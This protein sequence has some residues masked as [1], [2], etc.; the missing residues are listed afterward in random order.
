MYFVEL[1]QVI[2]EEACRLGIKGPWNTKSYLEMILEAKG[3][4]MR[5]L[6]L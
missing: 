5:I 2:G 1:V 6:K 3:I 4:F